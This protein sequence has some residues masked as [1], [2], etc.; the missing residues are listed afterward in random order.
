[1]W[2]AS[3]RLGHRLGQMVVQVDKRQCGRTGEDGGGKSPGSGFGYAGTDGTMGK[4]VVGKVER[5]PD[6]G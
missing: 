2:Y 3:A 5:S 6:N 4:G 1:M